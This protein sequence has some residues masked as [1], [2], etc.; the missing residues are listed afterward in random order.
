MPKWYQ[1]SRDDCLREL[2]V[3]SAKRANLKSAADRLARNSSIVPID[4]IRHSR[5]AIKWGRLRSAL[6][7]RLN[8]GAAVSLPL[9]ERVDATA[10][11]ITEIVV[12][13]TAMGFHQDYRVENA[14]ASLKRFDVPTVTVP[15]WHSDWFA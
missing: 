5:A 7:T 6:A 15:G 11:T 4:A 14:L 3:D 12:F 1:L 8:V 2:A 9:G 10:I 13:N